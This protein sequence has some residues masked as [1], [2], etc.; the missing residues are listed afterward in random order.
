MRFLRLAC[1][2]YWLMLTVL[3]L[4]PNPKALLGL[5]YTPGNLSQRGVHFL[6]FT[7]LVVLVMAGRPPLRRR[8]LVA[9]LVGYAVVTET[10]QSLVPLRTVELI[11]YLENLAGLAVGA[12]IW[13]IG[14][15]SWAA[16]R[17]CRR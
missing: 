9:V 17:R 14:R 2:A 1:A 8:T 3:L 15:K 4:V 7:V 5:R 10:L 16:I 11:D 12:G 13:L 6:F